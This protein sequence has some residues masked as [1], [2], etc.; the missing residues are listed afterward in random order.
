MSKKTK[1]DCPCTIKVAQIIAR[2][3]ELVYKI[4]SKSRSI[5]S[6]GGIFGSNEDEV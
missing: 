6:V 2:R 3:K 1:L 4:T 5:Y